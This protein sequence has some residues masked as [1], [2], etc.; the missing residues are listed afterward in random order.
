MFKPTY[1]IIHHTSVSYQNQ[2]DQFDSVNEYHKEK[3]N[4]K[5]KLGFYGGYNYIMSADG[6]IKQYR[7]E[8]EE[9]VAVIG[10]NFDSLHICLAGNFDIEEPTTTQRHNLRLWI[11]EKMAQYNVPASNV[12]PHRR[13]ANKSCCG[14]NLTDQ[15]LL[16]MATYQEPTKESLEQQLS[17]LQRLLVLLQELLKLTGLKK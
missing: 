14:K 6:I 2:P 8:G 4:M 13:F 15:Q 7:E 9:T 11:K 10:H 12:V 16:D 5:S 3:W 1:L 17:L